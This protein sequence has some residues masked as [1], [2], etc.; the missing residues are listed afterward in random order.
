MIKLI[1]FTS[2]IVL[3]TFLFI[4]NKENNGGN[5]SFTHKPIAFNT[6]E[7]FETLEHSM[8]F[9]EELARYNKIPFVKNEYV[10]AYISNLATPLAN[11]VQF[12]KADDAFV[13]KLKESNTPFI[14][15]PSV[16]FYDFDKFSADAGLKVAGTYT[17]QKLDL[18][19]Y[20]PSTQPA[21]TQDIKVKIIETEA[22]LKDADLVSSEAF[23]HEVGIFHQLFKNTIN[24]PN[25]ISYIAYVKGEAAGTGILYIKGSEGGCY[26]FG[27]R[28]KFQRKGVVKAVLTSVVNYA[29]KKGLKTLVTRSNKKSISAFQR[30]GFK[31]QGR[32]TA[33]I[34]QPDAHKSPAH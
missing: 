26:W 19:H 22:E 4:S 15:F 27:T 33:Y 5:G 1:T 20:D 32:F 17:V 8:F 16:T 6:K 10:L 14:G 13:T 31:P 11:Y 2:L 3:C 7:T 18:E 28:P 23:Q 29:H 21:Q 12:Q 30:M 34:W 25:I 9:W 24:K